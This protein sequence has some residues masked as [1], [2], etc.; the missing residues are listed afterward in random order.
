MSFPR[1]R[2][3]LL[4]SKALI[5]VADLNRSLKTKNTLRPLLGALQCSDIKLVS[6]YEVKS[7]Q[8]SDSLVQRILKKIPFLNVDKVKIKASGYL[9]YENIADR[10]DYINFFEKYKLP[11]TF[12]SWFVITEMHIWMLS[13]RAMAEETNGPI[14]RNS[15]VEALWADVAKRTKRLGAANPSIM[16]SQIAELSEQL[17]G[18]FIGYDEGLQSDDVVLAGAL[19]RRMYQKQY[20]APHNLE[21]FV[22]YIRKHMYLLD[23]LSM[24]EI[25]NVKHVKWE[26]EFKSLRQGHSSEDKP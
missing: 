8:K 7:T 3:V 21:G 19:W 1:F 11:D 12:Y 10:I 24:E 15:I 20:A 14:L 18:A 5:N 23:N 25:L 4:H 9:L 6:T 22:R 17:Q 13:A 26:G 2:N 16:R